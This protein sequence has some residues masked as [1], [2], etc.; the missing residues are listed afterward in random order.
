MALSFDMSFI[1]QC[2]QQFIVCIVDNASHVHSAPKNE[3]TLQHCFVLN[4]TYIYIDQIYNT[5][6]CHLSIVNK[7]VFAYKIK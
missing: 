6:W 1:V 7:L 3:A 2:Q 5:K 4:H